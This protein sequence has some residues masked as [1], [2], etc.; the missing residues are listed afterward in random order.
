MEPLTYDTPGELELELRIPAG[1]LVVMTA[2]TDHTVLRISG[3]RDADEISVRFEPATSGP[4][5]LVVTQRGEGR[6]WRKS[7]QVDV[8]VTVPEATRLHVEGSSVD[9]R[10]EG[11]LTSLVFRA[12]SG[13]ADVDEVRQALD[14]RTA[15]GDL[16]ARSV[17][18]PVTVATASGDVWVDTVRGD[19]TARTSSG[20]VSLG[21]SVGAVRIT[22]AS[23][24]VA[25]SNAGAGVT[26]VRTVSGD[27]QVGVAPQ[28]RAHLDVSSLSGDTSSELPVSDEPMGHDAPELEL[29]VTSTSG[30]VRIRR[31]DG[32]PPPR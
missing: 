7:R 24:D 31:G 13:D 11:A 5:R 19:V 20:D 10:A 25:L 23:G 4:A 32:P 21:D 16:R 26:E 28:T 2:S 1:Q 17:G 29:R 27:V 22:T 6:V 8:A 18:G 15:S 14:L 30:D 3:E 9:L 12:A